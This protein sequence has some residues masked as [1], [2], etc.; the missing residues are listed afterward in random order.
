MG[1]KQWIQT[2]ILRHTL[3][4]SCYI[5]LNKDLS[6]HQAGYIYEDYMDDLS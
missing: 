3:G 6:A 4:Y 5:K 1:Q 2:L